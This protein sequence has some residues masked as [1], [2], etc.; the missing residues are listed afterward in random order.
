LQLGPGE[1][2]TAEDL[3]SRYPDEAPLKDLLL[4]VRRTAAGQES[5]R[6][7]FAEAGLHLER[8]VQIEPSRLE[9]RVA[10]MQIRLHAG[11][12][13]TSEAV[14]RGIL[15]LNPRHAAALRGLAYSLLRQDRP[16]EAADALRSSLELEESHEARMMLSDVEKTLRDERGL[17]DHQLSHFNVR[18]DGEAHEDVGREVLRL[19]ERHYATLVVALDHQPQAS[20]PVILFTREQ[21]R[22][23]DGGPAWS[24]G[25]YDSFDGRIRVPVG[26]LTAALAP[27]IDGVLLHELTHALIADRTRGRAPRDIHEGLAQYMEGKRTERLLKPEHLTALADGRIPGVH[28]FYLQALSYVEY[29]VGLRGMGGVNDLL[30]AMGETTSPEEAFQ[31]VYGQASS[32]LKTAW[33]TRLRQQHG[34]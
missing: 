11:D 4:A 22:T 18:Y 25:S 27:D 16:R 21:Y 6:S 34:S 20:V 10:L 14:A 2:A 28:G 31:R 7:R 1:I 32:S 26:G 15:T 23:A 5:A 13:A 12:W 30:K 3:Y 8:A 9:S 33:R 19:L 17:R 29:L 24:A